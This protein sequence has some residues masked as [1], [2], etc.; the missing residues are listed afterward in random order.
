M[1]FA[2]QNDVSRN[3]GEIISNRG[4]GFSGPCQQAGLF[5]TEDRVE[6][7]TIGVVLFG[8]AKRYVKNGSG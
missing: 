2:R 3:R 6:V 8:V 1:L 4:T 5:M 7:V